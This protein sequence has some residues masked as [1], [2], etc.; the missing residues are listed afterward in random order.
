MDKRYILMA[1][2]KHLSC[3]VREI[4]K[5]LILRI[6]LNAPSRLHTKARNNR[7]FTVILVISGIRCTRP[8]IDPS[9]YFPISGLSVSMSI[10]SSVNGSSGG[11]PSSGIPLRIRTRNFSKNLRNLN[12]RPIDA[13]LSTVHNSAIS[14]NTNKIASTDTY[15]LRSSFGWRWLINFSVSP[16]RW[17]LQSEDETLSFHLHSH[18]SYLSYCACLLLPLLRH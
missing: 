5:I 6:F 11:I 14:I 9:T 7:F 3:K 17:L 10:S 1:T 13:A 4:I 12:S 2:K 15:W 8:R 16:L 18:L